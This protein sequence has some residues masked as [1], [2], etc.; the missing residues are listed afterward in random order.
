MRRYRIG[1]YCILLAVL[2]CKTIR[3]TSAELSSVAFNCQ[4]PIAL[5]AFL[6]GKKS[7]TSDSLFQKPEEARKR[8]VS[9]WIPCNDVEWVDDT[10]DLFGPGASNSAEALEQSNYARV[11]RDWLGTADRFTP[12]MAAEVFQNPSQPLS[13]NQ[14]NPILET[15][16]ARTVKD[17]IR[18]AE[19]NIVMNIF[20][21]GGSWGAEIMHDLADA[22]ERGVQVILLHDNVSKFA[23]ANEMDPLW[24]AAIQFSLKHPRFTALESNIS[25]PKRVSSV[26]FGLEKLGG[27]VSSLMD[28]TVSAEGKSDHS[29]V[30]IVDAIFQDSPEE[31]L[32]IKPRALISSRNMVDSAAAFYHDEAVIVK[33]PAAVITLLAFQSDIFWAWDQ[34][35][36]MG[37][38]LIN[39]EDEALLQSVSSRLDQVRSGPTLVKGQGFV[40]VQPI[41]ISANDEVRNLD[42][43]IIPLIMAAER[44]IDIYDRIAY[45]WP[46]AI[47]LKEAMARGVK[48]RV[49]MD[50]Q[51]VSSALGNAVFPYMIAEAPRRLP[52]GRET[53]LLIDETGKTIKEAD[54]PVKW[55]LPFRPAKLFASKDRSDL[56][57]EIHAKTIIIDGRLALFGSANFDQLS[58]AG[59]FREYSVWVDDPALASESAREFDRLWNHPLLTISHKIW[60]GDAAPPQGLIDYFKAS[61]MASGCDGKNEFCDFQNIVQGGKAYGDRGP[62][63]EIIR[64]VLATEADRIRLI[65]PSKVLQ[66]AK[67]KPLCRDL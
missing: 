20:L 42:S 4:E 49:I 24:Q 25:P 13:F 33:G 62:I 35:K 58:W 18:G 44:T 50:Q 51:N 39:A 19:R 36:K 14:G 2:S 47:A 67:G 7:C 16:M 9:V 6:N 22:A 48:V 17:L 11:F 59:G 65:S 56:A 41:Q 15:A 23:V 27:I 64:A 46:L 37:K 29:K 55:F 10:Q 54:L 12:A 34:A 30:L 8:D 21:L 45:N 53:K 52:N 1:L 3:P 38:K 63:R 66:D 31:Y 60:M 43:G 32:N 5:Q 28:L 40:N 61:Q 26:P 57:Q